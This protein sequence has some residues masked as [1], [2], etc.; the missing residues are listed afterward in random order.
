MYKGKRK[1]LL[2]LLIL[3]PILLITFIFFVPYNQYSVMILFTNDISTNNAK[4]YVEDYGVRNIDIR[5]A[6]MEMGDNKEQK[7][8]QCTGVINSSKFRIQHIINQLRNS[9]FVIKAGLEKEF[10]NPK[11]EYMN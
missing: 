9:K 3:I 7:I 11:M 10:W 2:I 6:D 1:I 8:I 5:S 4:K